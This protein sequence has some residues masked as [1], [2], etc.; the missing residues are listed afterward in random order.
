[1]KQL[2]KGAVLLSLSAALMTACEDRAMGD[3]YI[4]FGMSSAYNHYEM[5]RLDD[6]FKASG[7]GINLPD[8]NDFILSVKDATGAS[9]YYGNYGDKPNPMNVIAGTYI[10]S[11]YSEEF[12]EPQFSTPQIGDQRTVVVGNGENIAVSFGCTQLN[13]GMRLIFE[14][15]F[16]D[17]F[18]SGTISINSQNYSLAY[19]YTENR[20]AYF[21]PGRLDVI[22]TDGA[23]ITPIVSRELAPADI[24]TLKLAASTEA[25]GGFSI[26][27]DTTRNWIE[28]DFTLGSGNDGSSPERA[29]HIAD[30]PMYMEATDV[31]VV[32]YIVGGDVSTSKV[33]F[34]GPFTKES[35]IAIAESTDVSSREECAAVELP[36]SSEARETLNLVDHKENIG[37]KVYFKGNIVSYYGHPGI[38]KVKDFQLVR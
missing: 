6:Y 29:L 33:N 27:V 14:K 22:H 2:L 30:L 21:N 10:L 5:K 31:W 12:K 9:I 11:V 15:S 8:T 37:K 16:R 19:P 35:H 23:K 13:S 32:G 17:K 1:M 38:K 28:E 34:D 20:I 4:S 26:K 18:F 3:A 7:T 36:S 25:P 24:Y